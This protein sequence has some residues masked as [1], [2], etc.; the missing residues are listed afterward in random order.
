[1][2]FTCL[3]CGRTSYNP[4][5]EREGYCGACHVFVND[6]SINALAADLARLDLGS[7]PYWTQD[8]RIAQRRIES[9]R[10]DARRSRAD[11]SSD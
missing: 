10:I 1:M 7:E 3:I 6:P 2:S 4:A 8:V 9:A 5:D 11:Q